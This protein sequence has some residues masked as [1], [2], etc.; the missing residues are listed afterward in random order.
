MFF[1]ND[2]SETILLYENGLFDLMRHDSKHFNHE[3]HAE[4]QFALF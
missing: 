4:R 3:Q 1:L 2:G